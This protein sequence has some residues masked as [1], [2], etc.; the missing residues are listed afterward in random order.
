MNYMAI[1]I[2]KIHP[3][4]SVVIA[5]EDIKNDTTLTVDGAPLTVRDDVPKGHKI[6]LRAIEPGEAIRKYG[7]VI[8]HASRPIDA[9]AWVHAHNCATNLADAVEYAY[10]PEGVNVPAPEE[11]IPVFMGYK[12]ADGRVGTRNEIWIINT[13]GC[14]NTSAERIAKIANERFRRGNFDGVYAFSH[15]F[16]CSQL[17]GDH[18]KTRALLRGLACNPNAGGVLVLGLGCENNQLKQFLDPADGMPAERI[19]SF[20]AQDVP[21]EIQEGVRLIG[22]LFELM[23]SDARQEVPVSELTLG[24]KCGGSD[25]FSGITANPL[26]GRITDALTACGGRVVLTEVPEMFGAEQQLMNRA[27]NERVFREI[28][29]LINRFKNY[30]TRHGQPVYENPSP[31]NKAGGITTL[32]EKS[33]GAIQ[34]GGTA[35]V[36]E[37]LAYGQQI[38]AH[39]MALLDAPGNDGVSSTAMTAS[40]ATMILFTTGRG[41][42]LGFPV[43]T[44]KISTNSALKAKKP[45]W[46]D[47]D[48]G[49]LVDGTSTME[50]LTRDLLALVIEA[51]SGRLQTKNELNGCREIAIW[52]EGV[53]L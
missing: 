48:A 17:G 26:V 18:E 38:S 49:A 10:A 4:D 40:G 12:R 32:E 42:P 14:V 21:D 45:N 31:G 8:G 30:F 22:E 41:T 1:D 25:G 51:A 23:E 53:T 43:P 2:I 47:F 5:L 33:L 50:E 44:L 6:A 29:G 13:V 39:G 52:K 27:V 36:H 7:H 28:V 16:G 24:M 15:P 34:K 9:G 3:S 37:V 19:R 46:I 35:A 11:P 20:N